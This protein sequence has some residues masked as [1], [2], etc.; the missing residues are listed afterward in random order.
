MVQ[1]RNE[2]WTEK[3]QEQADEGCNVNGRIRVNKVVS[4]IHLSPGRSF[5]TNYMNIHELV[6]YLKE[7]ADVHNFG[8]V[9]HEL[10][11]EGDDEYSLAKAE[12]SRAMK[13][14]LGI[15]KNPLDNTSGRV[16]K[17][18]TKG[19][20]HSYQVFFRPSRHNICSNTS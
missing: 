8:H 16:R 18:Y 20:R 6:P 7:E 9:V 10:K 4:N 12:K 1:C 2:N 3:L 5:Q 13:E 17:A 14:K 11:F 19:F 15:A